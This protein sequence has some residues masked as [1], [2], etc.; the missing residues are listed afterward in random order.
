MNDDFNEHI[1]EICE[2]HIYGCKMNTNISN[3]CDGNHCDD[4]VELYDKIKLQEKIDKRIDAIDELLN[5]CE[6]EI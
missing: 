1:C 5:E 4:V 2:L 6:H 3:Q